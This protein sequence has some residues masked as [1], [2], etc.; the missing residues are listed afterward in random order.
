LRCAAAAAADVVSGMKPG[1]SHVTYHVMIAMLFASHSLVAQRPDTALGTTLLASPVV[2]LPFRDTLRLDL[3]KHGQ[4]RIAVRP[5]GAQL[6]IWSANRSG[7]TEFAPRV[8]EGGESSPTI[9]ELHPQEDGVHL[10]TVTVPPG[11]QLV[12]LSVWEDSIAEAA[13]Q[14]KRER[15]WSIGLSVA[16]GSVSGYSITRPGFQPDSSRASQYTEGAAVI[17]SGSPLS[18]VL[19]V[20]Y[21]PRPAI[22]SV[23]LIWGFFELRERFLHADLAGRE[24]GVG[25]ALRFSVGSTTN[26][27]DDR[28]A[29]GIGLV[30]AWHLD[31]RRG[32]RGVSLGS[33]ATLSKMTRHGYGYDTVG[34]IAVSLTWLP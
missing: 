9:I 19:G 1:R 28:S 18:L 7:L 10:M 4:Y 3:R 13:T 21:D 12:R 5:A 30:A 14:T 26:V 24:L 25:A 2:R 11:T 16:V 34:R 29:V 15:Q 33:E 23:S 8:R 17:G 22:D 6:R 27:V 20:Q 31:R 32:F